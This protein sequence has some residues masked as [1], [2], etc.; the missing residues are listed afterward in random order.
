MSTVEKYEERSIPAIFRNRAQDF[1]DRIFARYRTAEGWK[2]ITWRESLER[3]DAAASWLIGSGIQ[4]DDKISIFSENR[5]EWAF[6]D[7]AV[8]S[9]GAADVTIYATNSAP[10]LPISSMIPIHVSAS[11]PGRTS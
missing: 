10:R 3:V 9:A 6:A 11:V 5:P 2:D 1:P 8:L 4:A 7:L